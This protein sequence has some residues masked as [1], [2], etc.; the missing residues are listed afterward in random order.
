[1]VSRGISKLKVDAREISKKIFG[2]IGVFGS[3][4]VVIQKFVDFENTRGFY[5]VGEKRKLFLIFEE[6]VEATIETEDV[7]RYVNLVK[8][9]KL[10][11]DGKEVLNFFEI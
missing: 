11:R 10:Y 8:I 9:L 3:K 7:L 6:T 5:L 4:N 2:E 1:M